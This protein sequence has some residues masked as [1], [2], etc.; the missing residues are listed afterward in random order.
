MKTRQ[1]IVYGIFAVILALAFTACDNDP[2]HTHEYSTT[3]SYNATQHWHECSCGDKADV[4]N[5][6]G[7]PCSVCGYDSLQNWTAVTDSTIWEG[8]YLGTSDINA[9][10]YGNGRFIAGGGGEIAYSAD[11]VTWTA[12]TDSISGF[13][14]IY[15]IAYGGGKFV[16]VGFQ[17]RMAYSDNGENWTA[18]ADSKFPGSIDGSIRAIA[19]GSAGNT[20]GRFVAVGGEG[21]MAYSDNGE[22]WLAVEDSTFPATYTIG[23]DDDVYTFSYNINAIAYGNNKFVAGGGEGKMAYSADGENWTVVED[24]TFTY[25]S[26]NGIAY[27]NNRFVA[28][29]SFGEMAYSTDGISWTAVEDSILD[30]FLSINGIAY[31]NGRF[32]A[33]RDDGK[34]AYSDNGASWTAVANSKFPATYTSYDYELSYSINGI[35]YGNGRFVAVGQQGKMAYADW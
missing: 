2:G 33:V 25:S 19:Y 22:N 24:S 28:V 4:A 10:A 31:G 29:G 17:G 23:D 6:T 27:G 14:G 1:I 18:V 12:V 9:I 32:V 20:G 34:I 11:G 26:I 3:W 15:D 16:A 7:N 5:H 13:F 21:K 35:A 30:D 8:G